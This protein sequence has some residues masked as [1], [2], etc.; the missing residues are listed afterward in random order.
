MGD[1]N[2]FEKGPVPG[3]VD[4]ASD[5]KGATGSEQEAGPAPT[6]TLE[7]PQFIRDWSPEQR[8]AI[9]TRLK[10]KIDIRLMPMIILSM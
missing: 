6:R 5:D 4:F 7:V 8:A 1:K 9:E 2:G 3:D 10:R